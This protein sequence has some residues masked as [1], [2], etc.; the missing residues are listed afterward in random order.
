MNLS[1]HL[2]NK[3]KD[4]FHFSNE[5]EIP[6]CG[7]NPKYEWCDKNPSNDKPFNL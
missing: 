4:F 5:Y 7:L 1:K 6:T 3:K 2:N